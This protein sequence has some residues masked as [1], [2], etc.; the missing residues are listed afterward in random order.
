MTATMHRPTIPPRDLSMAERHL[1]ETATRMRI[2][3]TPGAYLLYQQALASA[4]T[5]LGHHPGEEKDAEE[6]A[7]F[8][9]YAATAALSWLR[10]MAETQL[11]DYERGRMHAAATRLREAATYLDRLA[12]D[13]VTDPRD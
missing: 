1:E 4:L 5:E 10:V 9:A 6:T 12:A 8:L 11:T 3:L 2:T 13:T 7:T